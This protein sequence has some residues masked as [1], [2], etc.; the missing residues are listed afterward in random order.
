MKQSTQKLMKSINID[1]FK[2]LY[3]ITTNDNLC[4]K[5]N[6]NSNQVKLIAKHLNL[7]RTP[8]EVKKLKEQTIICKYGSLQAYYKERDKKTKQTNLKRY[9]NEN[10]NCPE[11]CVQNRLKNYSSQ[12]DYNKH[13]KQKFEQTLIEKYGNLD[14]YYKVHSQRVSNT[15]KNRSNEQHTQIYKKVANTWK[16]KSKDEIRDILDKRNKTILQKYGTQENYKINMLNKVTDTV[17][18]RYGVPWSCMRPEAKQFSGNN[19]TVNK[20]FEQLLLK[21]NIK[22]EREVNVGKYIFDFMVNDILVEINPTITHNSIFSPYGDHKGIDK[23]YHQNKTL[24]AIQN[25]YK[26][27]H[28]WDWDDKNKII[29]MLL[30]K[31]SIYAR[32]CEL[33]EVDIKSCNEF[34]NTYHLQGGCRGQIICIGLYYNNELVQ[35]ITFGKPRY[36]KNYEWELLRLCTKSNF[37]IIGGSQKLFSNFCT[38]YRPRCIISYC[39]NSKFLGNV[40]VKLGFSQ[41]SYGMPSKH[42]YNCN[43]KQHI[44][45]NL[46][47]QRGFDQLFDTCYGKG[48]SNEELMLQSNFF[49]VFDCGQ[50]VYVFTLV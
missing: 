16:N 25:N 12:E 20:T 31:K 45:D 4:I 49:P 9:G 39:D 36:N 6:L 41:L 34:V 10:Y 14:N 5:F 44:T 38:Q 28:V 29:N 50:S 27:I 13:F 17:H 21:N 42:W 37:T 15:V 18:Q 32:N 8:E 46:L 2:K 26:C 1:E 19:S 3:P 33:R 43:T 23:E 35:V 30:P 11:K 48:T 24:C 47:R 7:Q 22:Y 40:Y